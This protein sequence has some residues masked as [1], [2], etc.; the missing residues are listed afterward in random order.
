[1]NL[2]N[3]ATLH[4][5]PERLSEYEL[6]KQVI[7][8]ENYIVLRQVFDSLDILI[9]VINSYRQAIYVNK[10]FLK[11]FGVKSS[12][13]FIGKK[14]GEIL[15]C[16]HTNDYYGGCGTSE[17]CRYCNGV[18]LVLKSINK[19]SSRSGEVAITAEAY[20]EMLPMNFL[21][22]VFPIQLNG[23]TFYVVS[24][25]D[26]SDT[27][28][29]I[30]L[31][32]IFFHDIINTSGALRNL[33]SMLKEDVPETY[34][35]EVEIVEDA[36]SGLVDEILEQKQILDAESNELCTDFI[37]LKSMDVI[38]SVAKLYKNHDVARGKEI[39]VSNDTEN[40]EFRSDFT[41]LKRVL[42]NM[43]KNALESTGN[44]GYVT[45]GCRKVSVEKEY[46]EFW[47][48]NKEMMP[49]AVQLQVFKRSFSTKGPGRGLGTYSMKLFGERYL[50]GKVYF[51]SNKQS[52]TTFYL[53]IS[54]SS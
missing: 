31:E 6:R 52:G 12:S 26:I 21:E 1:M 50:K 5:S 29:R 19:Q 34:K 7:S 48:N 28:R 46:V 43:L 8:F 2:S 4:A 51:T 10:A 9:L 42:A 20:G 44:E 32:R 23:E 18:N 40:I 17:A 33:V 30:S 11:L 24:L 35:P 47:V 25:M 27:E 38:E 49:R 37:I 13:P 39:I 22:K 53:R 54:L 36:F 16:I 45:I 41:I 14:P 3:R 15:G